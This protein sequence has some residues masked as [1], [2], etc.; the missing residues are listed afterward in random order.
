LESDDSDGMRKKMVEAS[1]TCGPRASARLRERER[2]RAH[3]AGPAAS[4][5]RPKADAGRGGLVRE[6]EAELEEAG[7]SGCWATRA[8]SREGGRSFAPLF[9]QSRF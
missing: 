7:A 1:L 9:F 8:E 6:R 3:G 4:W 5:A 2:G